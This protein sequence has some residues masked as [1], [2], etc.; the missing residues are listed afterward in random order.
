MP[1]MA[2]KSGVL[3]GTDL[4]AQ[5]PGSGQAYRDIGVAWRPTSSK[6]RS[7]RQ[8]AQLITEVLQQKCAD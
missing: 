7:Y 4:I 2:I 8:M 6:L 3:S 1:Q 5:K